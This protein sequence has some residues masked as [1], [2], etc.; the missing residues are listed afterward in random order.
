MRCPGISLGLNC[1]AIPENLK[2]PS[3]PK[4]FLSSVRCVL[5]CSDTA[6]K[7]YQEQTHP[8][9]TWVLLAM[10]QLLTG[11]PLYLSETWEN[12]LCPLSLHLTSVKF[13][14]CEY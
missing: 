10:N 11:F 13:R 6:S 5:E 7:R 2:P 3:M 8:K 12:G 4:V 14:L 1:E 9:L